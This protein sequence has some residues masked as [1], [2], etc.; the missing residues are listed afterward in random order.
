MES[1]KLRTKVYFALAIA[2]RERGSYGSEIYC[3]L[4][5]KIY[6]FTICNDG[7]DFRP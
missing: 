7:K 5:D 1:W 4:R 6:T 2:A 3:K